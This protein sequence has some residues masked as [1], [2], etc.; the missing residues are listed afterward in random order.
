MVKVPDRHSFADSPVIA[1]RKLFSSAA[2]C[3]WAK[4][5]SIWFA[6]QALSYALQQ[7]LS[8][9]MSGGCCAMHRAMLMIVLGQAAVTY[10]ARTAYVHL[11]YC[12]QGA[13]W[14]QVK[15]TSYLSW[16]IGR[17]LHT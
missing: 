10:I 2:L 15:A 16:G 6:F 7:A 17:L 3:V 9:S 4:S 14:H 13:S 8:V 12:V 11:T 1:V 5:S